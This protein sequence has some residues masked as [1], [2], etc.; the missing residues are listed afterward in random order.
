MLWGRITTQ[1]GVTSPT[2]PF[3]LILNTTLLPTLDAVV[4]SADA[5]SADVPVRPGTVVMPKLPASPAAAMA[6]AT[7]AVPRRPSAAL[8]AGAASDDKPVEPTGCRGL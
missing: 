3:G 4:P 5:A 6:A 1:T 8:S 2:P 7:S